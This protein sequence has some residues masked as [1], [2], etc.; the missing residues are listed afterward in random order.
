MAEMLMG[1]DVDSRCGAPYRQSSTDRVNQRNGYRERRWDTRVG[2]I[3]L[4]I[5]RVRRGS[6]FP[7]W[8]LEPRRRAERALVQVVTE[9]YVRG[10]STRRVDGLVRSLGLHGMSKSQVSELAKE[11][12]TMVEGFRNRPLRDGPYT[13]VWLDA[14]TQRCREGGRVVNVATLIATGVNA[15]GRREVLGLEVMTGEDGPGWKGFLR[16][17]V[18]RGLSGVKLVISDAHEGLKQAVAEV[19]PGS[20][21]Q[22]CRTHFTLCGTSCARCPRARRT[23]WQRSCGRSSHSQARKRSRPSSSV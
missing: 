6:Y 12:D 11:L 8:L 3:D 20:S 7:D 23:P 14:V 5:P 17:L 21:W 9:C 10:V 16:G 15:D 19:L 2:T 18:S 4:A 13:F 22:R 1:A